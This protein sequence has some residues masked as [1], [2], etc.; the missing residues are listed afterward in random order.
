M[1]NRRFYQFFNTLHHKPV[2]LD[3]S[4]IVD[5]TNANGL[6]VRSVKG[7]GISN[8][9]MNT[10]PVAVPTTSVFASGAQVIT[11]ASTANLYVGQTVTDS[12]TGA[13]ITSGTTVLAV[14]AALNQVTLSKVTAGA[15]TTSPG[16]TLD[17]QF[18]SA[19]PGNPN[20]QAGYAVIQFQDTYSRY[21]GG[22]SGFVAPVSGTNIAVDGSALTVGNVY[23]ITTLG[24]TTAAD[25]VTLGVPVGTTPGVGLAFV[26]ASTGTGS[27]SGKVQ[28]QSYADVNTIEVVGDSNQSLSSTA[29]VVLGVSGSAYVIVRFMAPGWITQTGTTATANAN[30]TSLTSTAGILPGMIAFG[31]GVS[32]GSTV[33]SITSSTALAVTQNGAQNAS[34]AVSFGP[35]PIAQA[36]AN[37]SVVGMSFYLSNYGLTSAGD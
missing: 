26:A 9:F 4:F 36:P 5:Q 7:P 24:T 6:G 3:C 20:P 22:F 19:A 1:A 8:V 2:L 33:A 29:A 34:D 16:D 12:T 11:V 25:W 27:G 30:I 21:F 23:T 37:N 32:V 10:S 18:T 35:V 15:S 28:V 17:F 31:F 13:N 14:N